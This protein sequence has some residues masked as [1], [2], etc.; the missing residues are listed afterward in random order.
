MVPLPHGLG[1]SAPSPESGGSP[2]T[3]RGS[4]VRPAATGAV[5]GPIITNPPDSVPLV[6][7]T[8]AQF[9]WAGATADLV[10]ANTWQGWYYIEIPQNTNFW[11]KDAAGVFNTLYSNSNG[12]TSMSIGMV[13]AGWK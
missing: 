2:H 6:P 11:C 7:V 12:Y 8:D 5:P 4:C 10:F 1:F 3:T 13:P 9:G